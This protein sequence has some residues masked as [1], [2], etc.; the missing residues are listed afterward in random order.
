MLQ[1]MS[2]QL[3]HINKL[4]EVSDIDCF[5]NLRM[6]RNAFGRLCILL[7]DVGGLR[8]GRYVKLEEK[9]AI[10]FSI[11]AHHKKVRITGFDFKR[12]GETISHYVHLVLRAVLRLYDILLPQTEPVTLVSILGGNILRSIGV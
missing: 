3:K 11:L 8:N 7:R 1:R 4:V 12:S 9:V 5:N 2:P 10:F 6:D